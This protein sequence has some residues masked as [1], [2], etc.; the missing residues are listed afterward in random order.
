MKSSVKLLTQ[1]EVNHLLE[2]QEWGTYS[3]RIPLKNH[4]GTIKSF[5]L[6][7]M[8]S[9]GLLLAVCD[10]PDVAFEVG[11]IVMKHVELYDVKPK[12]AI[13]GEK[14][15][16]CK[17]VLVSLGFDSNWAEAS[18]LIKDMADI[19]SEYIGAQTLGVVTEKGYSLNVAQIMGKLY[20]NAN[21]SFYENTLSPASSQVFASNNFDWGYGVDMVISNVLASISEWG[22]VRLSL[23]TEKIASFPFG[24][25]KQT[26]IKGI[27]N[28]VRRY[29]KKGY[30][31][32]ISQNTDWKPLKLDVEEIYKSFVDRKIY[33]KGY[34][35]DGMII[36]KPSQRLSAEA[37]Q[38]E[39]QQKI[40]ETLDNWLIC[41]KCPD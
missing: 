13:I 33:L 6:C 39:L 30:V 10:T 1:D 24:R 29:I 23:P 27:E 11:E 12:L 2:V 37:E 3:E 20:P 41:G 9:L 36:S 7:N 15:Q 22:N 16:Q 34:E 26:G 31:Y 25:E 5:E 19:P 32:G 35:V 40:E 4:Y 38:V 17:D 28:F 18:L 8:P 21:L 14:A